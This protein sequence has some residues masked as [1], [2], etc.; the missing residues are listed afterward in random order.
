MRSHEIQILG[1]AVQWLAGDDQTK[2][3][4]G[5]AA[6]SF[7]VG[8]TVM[9]AMRPKVREQVD[10]LVGVGGY[11]DLRELIR[12]YTASQYSNARWILALG[13]AER[14]ASAQDQATLS[15]I[16]RQRLF[17]RS[18]EGD[19]RAVASGLD[20]GGRA[21]YRLLT[22]T[23]PERVPQLIAALPTSIQKELSALN[24]AE[25]DLSKLQARLI[26]VH[27]RAD[28]IIPHTES[29]ALAAAL[30]RDQAQL[31]LIDGLAHVDLQP[32]RSDLPILLSA[33]EALLAQRD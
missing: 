23:K 21:L 24:P 29:V 20:P 8:P 28:P 30:P 25:H 22:N 2:V 12:F 14:L 17:G 4:T 10:F 15:A 6:F 7:A 27:G 26:L 31:F 18:D 5:L 11:Y 32:E 9:A 1:A 13:V 33:I 16:A 19:E 3:S